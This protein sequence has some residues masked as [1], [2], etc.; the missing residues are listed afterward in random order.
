MAT[1]KTYRYTGAPVQFVVPAGV[2]N[3]DNVDMQGAAGAGLLD[4]N[5]RN[6]GLGA[7]VQGSFAVTPGETLWFYVGGQ[8]DNQGGWNGGG[9]N[10]GTEFGGGATDIRRG[11]QALSNRIV[12][13]AGGGAAALSGAAGGAGGRPTG[14]SGATSAQG[15]AGGA[16]ATQTAGGDNDPGTSNLNEGRLGFGG[17]GGGDN[18]SGGGGG[19]LYGGAAGF[20]G[21]PGEGGGGG[22]GGS[23]LAMSGGTYAVATSS[24]GLLT[25]TFNQPPSTAVLLTPA[26]NETIN[27]DASNRFSFQHVDPD[28]DGKSADDLRYRIVGAASWTTVSG[29]TPN[30]Y[31]DFAAGTFAA[32]SYEWQVR[33]YDSAGRVGSYSASGFFTAATPPPGPSITAPTAGATQG[34]ASVTMTWT[35]SGDTFRV[36]KVSDNA[37]APTSIVLD[38]SLSTSQ[39]TSGGR[40]WTFTLPVNSRYEHLQVQETASGLPF[41]DTWSSVRIF[42]NYTRPAVPTVSVR[43]VQTIPSPYAFTDAAEVTSVLSAPTGGQPQVAYRNVWCKAT[44][45][46]DLYRPKDVPVRIGTLLTSGLFIDRAPASDVDYLYAVEA[47]A[48]NGTSSLSEYTDATPDL[49]PSAEGA[50]ADVNY[51]PAKYD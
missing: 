22:G 33:T 4:I 35:G 47:V 31:R 18:P 17:T 37:G 5:R 6:G 15:R 32:G 44:T 7:R 27:R 25:F 40:S 28:G 49:P 48:V 20:Y 38:N 9:S 34:Q 24:E 1:R 43:V 41:G 10:G 19:G 46:G 50:Y 42:V 45:D 11:G 36:R 29:S 16:G 51:D 21:G 23:S 26:N 12:V 13:A 8:G 2:T 30:Q 14:F 39:P 3:I